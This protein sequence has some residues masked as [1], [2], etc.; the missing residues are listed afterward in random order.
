MPKVAGGE[1]KVTRLAPRPLPQAR[2]IK[3]FES[4]AGAKVAPNS[5]GAPKRSDA[6]KPSPSANEL[7]DQ[8][9]RIA[10]NPPGIDP[11]QMHY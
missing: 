11:R 9:N 1:M 7:V 2:S 4:P 10:K 6:L 8:F 5:Q 3:S